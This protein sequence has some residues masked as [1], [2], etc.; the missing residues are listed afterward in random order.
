MNKNIFKLFADL[1][2]L[3]KL[4][5]VQ[6]TLIYDGELTDGTEV[7]VESET[8]E[9]IP[10]PDGQY[11]D[12]T[13]RDGRIVIE[14]VVEE[15]PVEVVEEIIETPEVDDDVLINELT[16]RLDELWGIVEDLK[17]QLE[18]QKFSSITPVSQKIK[19]MSNSK[20]GALKYFE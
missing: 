9:M 20:K 7:F 13:V 17:K 3:G 19:D 4:E 2:K 12:Y 5:T 14:E 6:G 15:T 16:K 11:G 8:G 1:M 18:E 10:A